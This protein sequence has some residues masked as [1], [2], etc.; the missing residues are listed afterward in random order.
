MIS[1]NERGESVM[2][3]LDKSKMIRSKILLYE[4]TE[5]YR[6]GYTEYRGCLINENDDKVFSSKEEV[7]EFMEKL[8][9]NSKVRKLDVE[10]TEEE[11]KEVEEANKGY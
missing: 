8:V 10:L 5:D 2:E 3:K 1:M 9:A 11:I 7:D 6:K 4:E